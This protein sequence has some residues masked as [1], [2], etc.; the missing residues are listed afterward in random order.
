[1]LLLAC[2]RVLPEQQCGR[3]LGVCQQAAIQQHSKLS[4]PLS[5]AAP[6][7]LAAVA[8][9]VAAGWGGKEVFVAL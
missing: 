8:A 4:R 9:A 2:S 6:T 1:M 5:A 3:Q 7:R